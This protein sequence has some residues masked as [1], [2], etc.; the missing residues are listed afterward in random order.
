MNKLD[1]E[2]VGEALAAAGHEL[3]A[4]TEAEALLFVTC[5]VRDHA[6]QR[7]LS[8]LAQLQ[9]SKAAQ[10][11]FLV[12]VLGCMAQRLGAELLDRAPAVDLVCGTRQFGRI[13]AL[14]E[15]ARS[16]PVVAV[17]EATVDSPGI[18]SAH[19]RRRHHGPQAFISVMRG[20]NNF[21]AYC[22]VPH[23]R[24]GEESR[25]PEAVAAEA[26]AL[27]AQGAHEIT[28][29]GQNIDAYGRDLGTDLAE[30]L[31]LV[32]A[33]PGLARLRFVTSHPRD[34]TEKL[35][36]TVHELPN[37]CAHFHMPAQSGSDRMLA[38]MGRGY[39]R[40]EYDRK[41]ELIRRLAPEALVASDFIVGFPGETD[42]DFALTLELIEAAGY[43]NSYIFKYSP[44]PGTRA[45]A[46]PDDVPAAVKQERNRILLAAQERISR[47]RNE[48]LHGTVQEILVEGVSPRDPG[49]LIGRTAHNLICVFAL[50][51]PAADDWTGRIVRLRIVSSTPLTLH[52]ELYDFS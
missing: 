43:Q 13:S 40:A 23:V 45:A 19:E 42:A 3:T 29:L 48:S 12:G 31:R 7:V 10:P 37:V 32:H 35:V 15:Q 24:G 9:A 16:G 28:L 17:D 20:C 4:E 36:R 6:E 38:A 21:C 1:A 11:G 8:R 14:L 26:A 2:L 46:W 47:L 52:G 30:L 49:R 41:L 33:T 25:P 44:R 51:A 50:P 5:S 39:T 34:I 27:V 22:I 18:V